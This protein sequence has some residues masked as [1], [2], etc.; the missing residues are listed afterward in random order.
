MN[1]A[2]IRETYEEAS[3][4]ASTLARGLGFFGLGLIF[5][6]RAEDPAKRV[7][8]DLVAA[9]L[10]I[11][12]SL[13]LDFVHYVIRALVW[14]SYHRLLEF[15]GVSETKDFAVPWWINWLTNPFYFLK[16]GVMTWAY[17]LIVKYLAERVF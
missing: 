14:N 2:E 3:G 7:P 17:I 8:D 10:A 16:L 13:A 6:F 12:F 1:L 15:R 5:T 4:T 9:A 11:A